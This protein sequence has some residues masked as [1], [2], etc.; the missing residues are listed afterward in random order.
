M[1][2]NSQKSQILYEQAKKLMPGGVNSPVRA[3]APYPFF[4][5]Y[6]RGSKIVDVDGKYETV[7]AKQTAI[8]ATEEPEIQAGQA[9][10]SATYNY[11]TTQRTS[12]GL[13]MTN[14][15]L[16]GFVRTNGILD[17][18]IGL[19]LVIISLGIFKK[20]SNTA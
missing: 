11:L 16:A 13:A 7:K 19:G 15:G 4:T 2:K 17:I 8:A 5:K 18:V 6:S 12:L 3:F 20:S 1:E 10:P 14:I 9:A